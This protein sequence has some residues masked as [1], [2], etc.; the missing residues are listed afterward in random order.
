MHMLLGIPMVKC[1]VYMYMQAMLCGSEK[2]TTC[3]VY[4]AYAIYKYTH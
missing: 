3:T 2:S 1:D 4:N